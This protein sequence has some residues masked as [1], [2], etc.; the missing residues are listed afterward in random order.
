MDLQSA[1]TRLRRTFAY[2]SD[3]TTTSPA[4]DSGSEGWALDEQEQEDLIQGLAQQNA[5]RNA[6]FRLF[7]LGLPTLSTIPYLMVLFEGLLPKPGENGSRRSAADIWIALLALSSLASTA[8]MLW[9]LP[10]GVT[11]IRALDA[12]VGS[13]GDAPEV[14]GNTTHPLGPIGAN[15]QRRRRA[16][17]G[18]SRFFL[19]AQRHRSPLEQYL[20]FLNV[21]ICS[22]LVLAGLLSPPRSAAAQHWGHIGLANLP[23]VIYAVVL[24]AK[25]LMGSIDPEKELSAL[26][27]EYKGA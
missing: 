14:S 12:W 2:P 7:L 17:A 8:W 18:G 3:T 19:W 1:T 11:G 22:L 24:I 26:R 16:S 20:P 25:T 13:G 15:A 6:Q 5:A 27:Y 4:S 10:P 21:A 9:S 23:A